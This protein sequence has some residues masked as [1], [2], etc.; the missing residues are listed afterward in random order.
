[1]S[2]RVASFSKGNGINRSISAITVIRGNS[3]GNTVQVLT[4]FIV[5]IIVLSVRGANL[6]S[7]FQQSGDTNRCNTKYDVSVLSCNR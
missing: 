2:N 4:T 6:L 7:L 5:L 3:A 1:M